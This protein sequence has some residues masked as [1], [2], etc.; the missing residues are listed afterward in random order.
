MP[1]IGSA[2]QN[3]T[4]IAGA[5]FPWASEG[6]AQFS[7]F[8]LKEPP[9]ENEPTM[10]NK[11][12]FNTGETTKVKLAVSD[13]D[14]ILRGKLISLEKFRSVAEKGFGFCDVIFGWDASDVAYDNASITGWHT[15]YPDALAKVDFCT[16]R[17]IPWENGLPFFMADFDVEGSAAA[18][19]CPRTLLKRVIQRATQQGFSPVISME[20]EWFNFIRQ[21]NGAPLP[22]PSITEGMFG[23]SLLRASNKSGYFH[24]LFDQL[25]SFNIPI[26][27]LHTETGPGV[28][29]AAIT[30]SNAL[31]AADRAVLFKSSVKEIAHRHGYLASFMAKWNENLPGCSGHTHQ[32]LWDENSARN[33]FYDGTKPNCISALMQ[34]YIAGQLHCL[35]HILPMYAPTINSY[36]RLVEG[37]WAPTTLTWGIDNRTTALRALPQG[38]SSCRLENRVVGSD[39]NPYLAIAACIASGL[40]GIEKGMK[41]QQPATSGNSYAELSFG[42]LPANL[43]EATQAMKRSEVTAELFGQ[44]FVEHFCGT[45][46]WEWR[47]HAKAVTDWELKRY[48]EII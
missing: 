18:E 21:D 38:E 15:G 29:E 17:Q 43:W 41:L 45:R 36:K 39:C 47:Q 48:L 5:A 14:G 23:Y 26:E 24:A 40:Y 33:L 46:E 3:F 30:Y 31:E 28:Y 9:N 42:K 27:G 35:P 12:K 44:T 2:M 7:I 16:E 11:W 22:P 1:L 34:S 13:I 8:Q 4:G 19:V 32:S 37:A 10:S 20:F 6:R 25:N